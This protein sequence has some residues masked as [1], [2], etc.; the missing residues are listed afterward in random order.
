MLVAGGH[1]VVA[2]VHLA[3]VALCIAM[4]ASAANV[5]VPLVAWPLLYGEIPWLIAALGSSYHDAIVQQWDLA[6]FRSSPAHS[7][8]SHLPWSWLSELLHAGYLA[9]YLAIFLPT[10]L[11]LW[12][13]DRAGATRNVV[14]LGLVYGCCWMIFAVF[15]V[16]GP[17]YLLPPP[18]GV[19]DGPVR[20]VALRLLA[21]GSS[22]GA[23]FPSSHMAATT[24]QALVV[25]PSLRALSAALWLIALLVGVGAVYGGFHYATDVVAGVGVAVIVGAS[26][27]VRSRR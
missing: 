26:V 27:L 23:A 18:P 9:Y 8:A 1:W 14:A 22:R 13:G 4:R 19:P 3:G 24:V 11:L 21:A 7:L 6:L 10:L 25:W 12:R 5:L 2:C 16:Q 17:R 20:G 15:P